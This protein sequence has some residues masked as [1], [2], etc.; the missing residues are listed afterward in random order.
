M[1]N[2]Y[3][4]FV[5]AYQTKMTD[6]T[7]YVGSLSWKDNIDAVA[8]EFS[9]STWQYAIAAGTGFTLFNN[10]NEVL[11]GIITDASYDENKNFSYSGYDY[12]LYLNKNEVIKQFNGVPASQAIQELLRIV[13]IQYSNIARIST[14]IQKIYKKQTVSDVIKDILDIVFKKTGVKYRLEVVQGKVQ[15]IPQTNIIVNALCQLSPDTSEFEI[16]K[17]L[18]GLNVTESIAEMKNRII[19]TD[20]S[21]DDAYEKAKAEDAVSKSKYGLLQQVEISDKETNAE[22]RQVAKNLLKELNKVIKTCSIDLLGNDAVKAGRLL[23]FDYPDYDF[24]GTFLIKS[25]NHSVIS[26]HKHTMSLE[27]E[28]K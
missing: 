9:F 3:K 15:V 28:K 1:M 7:K 10:S 25:S 21:Q 23:T 26:G 4:L 22:Q 5:G 6:I 11:R 14:P 24:T 8:T 20:N 2:N 18:A 13:D 17:S 16:Q 19:V 27:L 12:G